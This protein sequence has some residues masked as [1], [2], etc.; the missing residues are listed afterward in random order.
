MLILR[1]GP[2]RLPLTLMTFYIL[3]FST[4]D[5]MNKRYHE[6]ICHKQEH[7]AIE[8]F[9]Y[10]TDGSMN[11]SLRVP[12]RSQSYDQQSACGDRRTITYTAVRKHLT[13]AL[14]NLSKV[15]LPPKQVWYKNKLV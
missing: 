1:M 11:H 8:Y 9:Q 5:L 3:L 7:P 10:S 13:V 14:E 15:S 12:L 2:Q 4:L 6:A